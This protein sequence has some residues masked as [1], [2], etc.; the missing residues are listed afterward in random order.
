MEQRSFS[1]RIIARRVLVHRAAVLATVQRP[2][3]LECTV[4]LAVPRAVLL[5][6]DE[7]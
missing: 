4:R 5:N 6:A 3:L 2:H 1:T 7:N